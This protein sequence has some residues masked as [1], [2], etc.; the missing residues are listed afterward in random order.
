M[1]SDDDLQHLAMHDSPRAPLSDRHHDMLQ[2]QID[3]LLTHA[4]T[5]THQ[6]DDL[7]VRAQ[8]MDTELATS[9]RAVTTLASTVEAHMHATDKRA[10]AIE[11]RMDDF[12][13]GQASILKAVTDSG[14]TLQQIRD[15]RTAA[16]VFGGVIRG[17]SGMLVA[18]GVLIA[19][20][21]GAVQFIRGAPPF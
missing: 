21:A 8:R 3:A 15:G 11:R 6:I 13:L 18:L 10:T 1:N 12:S 19:A 4:R 5:V 17:T 16:R 7:T 20:V 14:E 9:N 2:R